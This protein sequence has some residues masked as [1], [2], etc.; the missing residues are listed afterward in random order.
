[1]EPAAAANSK[2]RKDAA[3][4]GRCTAKMKEKIVYQLTVFALSPCGW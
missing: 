1:M 3:C 4:E 2:L